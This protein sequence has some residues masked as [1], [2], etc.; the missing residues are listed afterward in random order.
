MNQKS[1]P[2]GKIIIAAVAVFII[3]GFARERFLDKGENAGAVGGE[4]LAIGAIGRGESV[5]Y[6]T[7]SECAVNSSIAESSSLREKICA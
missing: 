2:L 6:A 1:K 4:N 5:S 7:E 3:M